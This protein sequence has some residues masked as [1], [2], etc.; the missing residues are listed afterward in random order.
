MHGHI[1]ERKEMYHRLTGHLL[2]TDAFENRDQKPQESNFE[3]N[4]NEAKRKPETVKLEDNEEKTEYF[5]GYPTFP[6]QF[7]P[8]VCNFLLVSTFSVSSENREQGNN[9]SIILNKP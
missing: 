3:Y 6:A 8:D 1:R 4:L 9:R 7:Q 5:E 2:P